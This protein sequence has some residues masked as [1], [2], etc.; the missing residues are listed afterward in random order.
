MQSDELVSI[1]Q[2]VRD[3]VRARHPETAAGGVEVPLAD[4]MPLVHARD[5]ALGKVAAIG[6][7]NPRRGGP[8]NALV[9][10]WKRLVAR[11][12]DWHVREQVEF[13]RHAVASVDAA[14]EAIN[15][16]NRALIEFGRRLD[17]LREIELQTEDLR[18]HWSEW[19][20]GWEQKLA[21]TEIRF[22]R[23]VA[24]FQA[25]AQHHSDRMDANFR[26][27]LRLQ[28]SDFAGALERAN[29]EIQK[30]LGS[31]LER[32]R[33]D[34][35]RVRGDFEHL[36]H[37]ELR[38]IRQRA[39][40]APPP[41]PAPLAQAP[42]A[43]AAELLGLDYARFAERFR[44][45]EEY[46]KTGQ[47]VYLPYFAGCRA[48]LDIGC[49]RGEFL[50]H[51]RDAGV[52]ARGIDLSRESVALCRAK[53]LEAETADL[54]AYLGSLSE[55]TLDGI[56]CSQVVEHLEPARLPEMIRLA[57]SRLEPNGLI[58]IETPN[59]ECLAIFATHFYLDPTHTRPVPHPLLRFYLEEAG[60]GRIELLRL[61]PAVESMPSLASLPPDFREQF[62][63][64]LDY[65]LVGRKLS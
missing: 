58:A 1:L 10:G 28:H 8:L 60:I 21:Q 40:V 15:D 20:A 61:S 17:S 9:Q 54:F 30:R 64:A 5:A 14:I 24:E 52:P 29:L 34:F 25:A 16:V 31:D 44:G 6:T 48:V 4:L 41:A 42:A 27:S 22:L 39:A 56:F 51:L 53:G 12:L 63:G 2:A 19:R 38:L 18:R 46:V 49:G 7:V 33:G 13:N 35:E 23:S 3:R 50:E 55:A 11:A 47:K 26:E 32:M 62:F 45:A 57:A 65:A 59:P 37:D 43:A 36:I